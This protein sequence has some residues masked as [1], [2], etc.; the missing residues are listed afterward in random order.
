MKQNK[1]L[2]GFLIVIL[3]GAGAL[4]FLL[5]QA[6]GKHTEATTAYAEKVT[7]LEG[8][9]A[10]KPFPNEANYKR[11]LELQKEHQEAINGL[12]KQLAAAEIAVEPLTPEK[13][14][15]NLRQAINRVRTLAAQQ[16]TQIGEG[17]SGGTA[18]KLT[19]GFEVYE[20]QPPKAEAAPQLGR[21]LKAIEMVVTELLNISPARMND[22]KRQPLPEEGLGAKPQ[23][24]PVPKPGSAMAKKA[25]EQEPLVK[26]Y[27][28]DLEF[29]AAEPRMRTFINKIV[30]NKQQFCIPAAVT[31]ANKVPAGPSKSAG[32]E[33]AP[34]PPVLDPNAPPA[35]PSS[36]PV[37]APPPEVMAPKADAPKFIVGEERLM[38]GIRFEVVDFAD[39]APEKS[40]DK[41]AKPA[42]AK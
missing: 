36:P 18:A 14:Q 6:K 41:P 30:S 40:A 10:S 16:G 27:P 28:F 22:I 31:V 35:A 12:Q 29:E 37:T 4:G 19:L 26:R 17:D 24:T 1:F 5:L 8:L 7:E 3:L 21:M 25:I 33:S 39:H 2:T 32:I 42:A 20:S 15:D 34:P 9:Y 38:V 13:F 23:A 11:V